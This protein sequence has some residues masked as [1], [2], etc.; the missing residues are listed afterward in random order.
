M[1]QTLPARHFLTQPSR[2]GR[3][4]ALRG[5]NSRDCTERKFVTVLVVD[6]KG[7]TDLSRAIPLE[8]WWSMIADLFE[9][10][11]ESVYQYGGWVGNF[12]GDGIVA[13]F[14]P[15]DAANGHARRACEAALWLCEAIGASAERVRRDYGLEL[16]IRLGLNSGEVLTGML[17]DRHNRYYIANGYAVALA[18]R[19]EA[20]ASS[21][22][23]YLSEYTAALVRTA[24][25]LRDLGPFRIKGAQVP[26]RVYELLAMNADRDSGTRG[27][28]DLGLNR[29]HLNTGP[30]NRKEWR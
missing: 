11:S 13:V 2:D 25:R 18:K 29:I 5:L 27:Q 26:L 15:L 28:R 7:S 30:T 3:H 16:S 24:V 8:E 22:R 14:E 23:V 4:P 19:M 20:I 12:T 21:G 9:L 10:M 6:V 17:G 1:E